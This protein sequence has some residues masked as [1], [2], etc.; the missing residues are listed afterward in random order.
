MVS[1][2]FLATICYGMEFIDDK[3]KLRT[4]QV[5]VNVCL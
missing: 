3:R 2:V 4:I 1:V 5:H